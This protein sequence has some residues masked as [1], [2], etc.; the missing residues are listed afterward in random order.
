MINLYLDENV[1]EAVA[2]G[3]RLRGFDVVTVRDTRRKGLSDFEQLQYAASENRAIFTFNVADFQKI[4]HEFLK[5][6]MEHKGII[7]SKQLPIGI[8]VKALLKL[9]SRVT[10]A[11]VKNN[12]IWLSDWIK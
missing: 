1:P 2:L 6:G 10:T 3:L 7:L 11:K 9:L 8:I 4:H 5:G 12:I